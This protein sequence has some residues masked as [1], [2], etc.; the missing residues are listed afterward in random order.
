MTYEYLHRTDFFFGM[1]IG[2]LLMGL[3]FVKMTDVQ[4]HRLADV[5]FGVLIGAFLAGLMFVFKM[6]VH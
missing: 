2:A 3:I 5:I 6:F 1:S 4:V